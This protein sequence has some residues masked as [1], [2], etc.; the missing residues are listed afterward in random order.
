M[1]W[2][3]LGHDSEKMVGCSESSNGAVGITKCG[4]F[5]DWVR[6]YKLYKGS[7]LLHGVIWEN[8]GLIPVQLAL[9]LNRSLI[10]TNKQAVSKTSLA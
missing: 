6:D 10:A 5:P 4:E 9:L 8:E 2:I 1:Y 7:A 3:D